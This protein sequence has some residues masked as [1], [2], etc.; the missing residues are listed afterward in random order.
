METIA[1]FG[2]DQYVLPPPERPNWQLLDHF[3]FRGSRPDILRRC[4]EQWPTLLSA[5]H[6]SAFMWT[7]NAATCA[8]ASDTQDGHLHILPANLSSN[9][10]RSCEAEERREQL[11]QLFKHV[12]DVSILPPLPSSYPIRD[13]GAANHMRLCGSS[14]RNARHL[15][16][17]IFVYGQDNSPTNHTANRRFISRQTQIASQLTANALAL[18]LD[19]C[20]F[21]EQSTTAIDGG[22]FHNDVI[23]T[24][25]E[26]VLIYHEDAFC[27][28]D[29]FI[30]Q[31]ERKYASVTGQP[32][33]AIRVSNA[34]LDLKEAV[35]CYLFNSQLITKLDGRMQLIAPVDCQ[36]SPSIQK[37][38]H[39]WCNDTENPIDDVLYIPLNQSMANGGGPACLRLRVDVNKQQRTLLPQEYA[40]NP[41]RAQKIRDCIQQW[42]PDCVAMNDL[43]RIDFAEHAQRAA[44]AMHLLFST[45]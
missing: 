12:P 19:H 7:A 22:V 36:S 34:E 24:S 31:T 44:S 3:G 40:I 32:L 41:V 16:I 4:M 35:A 5:A 45:S 21:V 11:N 37:L 26:N 6:S 38:I 43:G 18:P 15:A 17:H 33:V 42:Y 13:E 20:I 8:A 9:I 1:S 23:A 27:Q 14:L 39:R 30:E 2:V 25:H 28:S 29:A 10:H